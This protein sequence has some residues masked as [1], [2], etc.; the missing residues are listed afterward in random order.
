MADE[1]DLYEL[2]GVS[3]TATAVEIKKAY[4]KAALSSHPDKAKPEE[5]E[6]AEIR[7]KVISQAYEILSDDDKRRDYDQYGMDAFTPGGRRA[8]G[9]GMSEEEFF[10][11][12]FGMGGMG[13]TSGG[14]AR[15]N[16]RRTEDA[17]QELDVTLKALYKGKTEKMSIKRNIICTVC[18]GSGAKSSV[19]PR[20]CSKCGGHGVIEGL[21]PIGNGLAIPVSTK[22]P[23]CSGRGEILKEKDKCKKCKGQRIIEQSKILEIYIAP[24]SKDGD[25]IVLEGE[26]DQE[27]GKQTG[28]IIFTLH[29]VPDTTFERRGSDL[30]AK[31]R[32]TLV[33][34]LCGFSRG[35]LEHLD[36]RIIRLSI[37]SGKV[38]RPNDI[39]IVE[40]EGM[41]VKGGNGLHHRGDL[42]LDVEIEFPKDNWFLETSEMRKI[43][44]V[45]PFGPQ[46]DIK[47]EME[48]EVEFRIAKSDAE[49]G[50][51][52][53]DG[54][55]EAWESDRDDEDQGCAQ[56]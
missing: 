51:D 54:Q 18:K 38:L 3:R 35:I 28:N 13:G 16:A 23:V 6:D 12:F 27:P 11:E 30:R 55:S 52:F 15:R 4:H 19:K 47:G 45:L 8:G 37:P 21:R 26:A 2:L 32:I 44:D 25:K 7:F 1:S 24:G 33:E 42:Y 14:T 53:N 29:E 34:A 17:V 10:Q 39:L 5:R 46:T 9:P 41:P 40:N 22:C 50:H 20:K 43:A 31:L 56:Q 36:G 48:E 49:F